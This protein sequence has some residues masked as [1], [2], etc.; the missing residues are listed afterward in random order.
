MKESNFVNVVVSTIQEKDK[1]HYKKISKNLKE[2]K[3]LY[4]EEY[5]ELSG[6]LISYFKDLKVKPE[7]VAEHYLLMINDMRLEGIKFKRT[8]QYSCANQQEAFEKVYSNKKIMNYYMNGLLLSQILWLHHFRMLIYFKKMLALPILQSVEKVLDIGPGH[9][10][11]SFLVLKELKALK[12]I[13][14]VD[15]S[16]ES[17]S[18]TKSIIGDGAG[19]IT[20]YRKDIYDFSSTSKYDLVILGEVLEHLDDPKQIL[21]KLRTL[22]SEEGFLWIT[23]PTNA[24]ALDH[25]YLFNN[26]EE[27]VELLEESNLYIIE[28]F[29]CYAEEI[30]EALAKRFKISYLYGALLKS[31][32]AR[33]DA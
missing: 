33:Y 19:K 15:I 29:G 5:N 18:M 14:I 25:I 24:P 21:T 4:P 12:D 8:G 6:L 22:L 10:F 16:E 2:I 27:I 17:L 23:T 28:N 30:D 9:G 11:F 1:L 7:L 13:E 26:K 32:K 20:Y 31:D 3:L